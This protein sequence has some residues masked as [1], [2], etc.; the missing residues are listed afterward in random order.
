MYTGIVVR[1]RLTR[2]DPLFL[3]LF[4]QT[5]YLPP[6]IVF[7]LKK[8]EV[9]LCLTS[10]FNLCSSILMESSVKGTIKSPWDVSFAM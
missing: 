10:S 1:E 5:N 3:F 9:C 2:A 7:L 8:L 6:P 4:W